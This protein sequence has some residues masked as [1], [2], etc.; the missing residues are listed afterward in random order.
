M[1][2]NA[3]TIVGAGGIGC[4]VGHALSAAGIAVT[5]VETSTAKI[6]SGN[7]QGVGIVGRPCLPARF[8]H[9]DQWQPE[10]DTFILLC[11]KCYSNAGVLERIPPSAFLLPIQNGF[12]DR[13]E[14]R[15]PSHEGIAS[16]VSEC[17]QDQPLTRI[18]RPGKLHLGPIARNTSAAPAGKVLQTF[19]TALLSHA[20]FRVV[21]VPKILPYKYTKLMY[22][23][24]VGPVA[25]AAGIDNGSLLRVPILRRIFFELLLENYRILKSEG[26]ELARIGPFHPDTVARILVHPV[27][28]RTLA[29][30]FYPGLRGTYCSM[31]GDLPLGRTEIDNYN[32]HLLRLANGRGCALNHRIYGLIRRMEQER[33]APALARIDELNEA[34]LH[35]ASV[36]AAR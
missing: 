5:F 3:I 10:P 21:V 20:A 36:P 1:D 12:D 24:A 25:S 19:V 9:F 13:L 27:I 17:K 2:A 22:N 15:A 32:G 8:T 34:Q 26:I 6:E 23:A 14:K 18:T 29:W 7:K 33:L 16:F 11:T 30:A 28:A 35:L 4:A 31:A